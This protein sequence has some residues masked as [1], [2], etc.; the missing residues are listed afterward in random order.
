MFYKFLEEILPLQRMLQSVGVGTVC[1]L[2]VMTAGLSNPF[3]TVLV[4]G[5]R[6]CYAFLCA[7]AITFV[8]LMSCEEYA[9]YKT[10]RELE[11][12]IDAAGVEDTEYDE[13]R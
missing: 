3:V 2:I 7:A 1:G 4:A 11:E 12:F 8:L 6:A 5:A 10:K 13:E 9:I